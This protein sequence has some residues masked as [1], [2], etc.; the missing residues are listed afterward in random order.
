MHHIDGTRGPTLVA[1]HRR[2]TC[3]AETEFK[4]KTR[5]KQ[6]KLRDFALFVVVTSVVA[7]TT[8]CGAQ[9][10]GLDSEEAGARTDTGQDQPV[11][12]QPNQEQEQSAESLTMTGP[13][14]CT[15]TRGHSFGN[16][17]DIY[18][19]E[20]NF[21]RTERQFHQHSGVKS[22]QVSWSVS[23]GTGPYTL[24]IDGASED[25]SGPFSGASGQ[26]LVFCADTTVE[27]FIDEIDNRGFRANPM[28]DSGWKTVRA[29][30]TDGTGTAAETSI[31]V[32]VILRV[33]GTL[34]A[35]ENDQVLKRGQ[36][37]RVAGHLITAPATH[38]LFIGGIAERECAEDSPEGERCEEEWSFGIAGVEA[39][40]NLYRSDFAEASRWHYPDSDGAVGSADSSNTLVEGLLDDF[41]D[42]VGVQPGS[43]GGSP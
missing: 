15:T 29:V 30:V 32:Y 24:T 22:F 33:D 39:G 26:G 28:I 17:V 37:Y 38:D 6:L 27:T 25:R 5:L 2:R 18:D 23:G 8:V 9:E 19:D 1:A 16:D 36:T 7:V 21:L 41:V 13:S 11:Q 10:A 43:N 42:S 40:V 12:P 3:A 20:G 31:N 35:N 34:D 4:M 14:R